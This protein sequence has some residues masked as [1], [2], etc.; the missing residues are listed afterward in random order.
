M[1]Q[2]WIPIVYPSTYFCQLFSTIICFA[3]NLFRYNIHKFGYSAKSR[4]I[5]N[6]CRVEFRYV[7]LSAALFAT[8]NIHHCVWCLVTGFIVKRVYSIDISAAINHRDLISVYMKSCREWVWIRDFTSW[9]KP[10][11]THYSTL[12]AEIPLY[13]NFYNFLIIKRNVAYK[14]N[15][16]LEH[17]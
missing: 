2:I 10:A 8:W 1:Y 12:V 3:L 17:V 7:F 15:W 4:K 5:R 14:K 6:R 11:P 16:R 9:I 13:R